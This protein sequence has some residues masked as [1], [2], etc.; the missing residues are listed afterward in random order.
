MILALG[1]G[2]D[3]LVSIPIPFESVP[4]AEYQFLPDE[5]GALWRVTSPSGEPVAELRTPPRFYPLEVGT[6]Y[7]LGVSRDDRDVETV[8]PYALI[9]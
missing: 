1:F 6:D 2:G 5:G 8:E 7:V 3:T 4:V 9:R